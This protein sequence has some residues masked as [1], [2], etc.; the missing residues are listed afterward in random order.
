MKKKP[1]LVDLEKL[2]ALIAGL[3][4]GNQKYNICLRYRRRSHALRRCQVVGHSWDQLADRQWGVDVLN[5]LPGLA[6][7][8]Q[9]SISRITSKKHL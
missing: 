8:P 9:Q 3:D 2:R 7:R 6:K 1:V 5:D 4:L